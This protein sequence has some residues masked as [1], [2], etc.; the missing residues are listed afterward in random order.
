MDALLRHAGKGWQGAIAKFL[1]PGGLAAEMPVASAPAPEELV[2]L[3][4]VQVPQALGP[5][6]L[7]RV[8]VPG[9]EVITIS[10]PWGV[11]PSTPL[12]LWWDP[13]NNSLAVHHSQ[14][15]QALRK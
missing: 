14:D 8:M 12:K 2:Y 4:E 1:L 13:I 10:I 7:L 3:L 5:D 15:W 9:N 11:A 6:D